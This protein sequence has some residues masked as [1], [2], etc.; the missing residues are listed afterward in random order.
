MLQAAMTYVRRRRWRYWF[1]CWDGLRNG[2]VGGQVMDVCVPPYP[3][4]PPPH[5]SRQS[6]HFPP[7]TGSSLLPFPS[8]VRV[9]RRKGSTRRYL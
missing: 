1:C 9:R 6:R 5:G 2:G 3:T 7:K 4:D 8:Y